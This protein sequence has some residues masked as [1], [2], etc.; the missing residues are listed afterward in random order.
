M[1]NELAY[2]PKCMLQEKALKDRPWAKNLLQALFKKLSQNY[3]L[4]KII[5]LNVSIY[6][7]CFFSR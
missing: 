1:A 3:E 4:H 7:K 5:F 2:F 6:K